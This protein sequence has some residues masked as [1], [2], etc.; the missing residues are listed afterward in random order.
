MATATGELDPAKKVRMP[1]VIED[2]E[3][4]DAEG[5][6]NMQSSCH[7]SGHGRGRGNERQGF[8]AMA[9]AVTM[10]TG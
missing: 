10:M 4:S 6:W 2:D 9:I 1:L 7:Q 5:F 8:S 3:E